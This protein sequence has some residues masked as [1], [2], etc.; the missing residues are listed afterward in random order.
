MSHKFRFAI[1]HEDQEHVHVRVSSSRRDSGTW[2]TNGIL[3]FSRDEW[4]TFSKLIAV[5]EP[6]N[7]EER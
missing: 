4:K 7:R 2:A 6:M 3:V 5:F 1:I